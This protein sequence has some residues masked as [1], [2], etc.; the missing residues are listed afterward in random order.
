MAYSKR[1]AYCGDVIQLRDLEIDHIL[2]E[3]LQ[4]RP[5][6]LNRLRA[7]LGLPS[8]FTLSSLNNL[9][10]SHGRCN[11]Q[12]SNRVFKESRLRYFLEVA[13]GKL[14]AI[15]RLIPRLELH[16][17]KERILAAVKLG[18]ETG[19]LNFSELADVAGQAKGVSLHTPIQFENAEWDGRTDFEQIDNLLDQPVTV[20]PNSNGVNFV[21]SG[22]RSILVRTC[23]EYRAAVE[24]GFYPS[25]NQELRL[26]SLLMR[27]SAAL[28]AAS[29]ARIASVSYID[30]P[31]IGVA[32]LHLL[33]ANLLPW[34]SDEHKDAIESLC[35]SLQTLL[36]ENK[37]FIRS[38]S[39]NHVN[40]LFDGAGTIIEELLRA[41][42]DGDGVQ[43]I[44]VQRNTYLVSGTLRGYAI[45]I[46]S[47][48]AP[49]ALLSY[50][51]WGEVAP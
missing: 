34:F 9:L 28:E 48:P 12:K 33:P 22:G 50:Q 11:L 30:S 40:L 13:D 2:P 29:R 3:S 37:I 21:S 24:A 25:N 20:E 45:G 16:A 7:E 14:A 17:S 31:H 51:R 5:E 44:L 32:D 36:D 49:D 42:L 23:R 15:R 35:G 18:L 1:C 38:V 47:R 43:E 39:S 4:G 41:D 8:D 10:P 26:S 19:E 27:A 46:L 6:E